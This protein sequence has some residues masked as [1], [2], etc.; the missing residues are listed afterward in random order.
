M[1]TAVLSII[2]ITVST[3]ALAL[4]ARANTSPTPRRADP[5]LAPS[6]A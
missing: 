5:W 1:I 2:A 4:R 3:L 6:T